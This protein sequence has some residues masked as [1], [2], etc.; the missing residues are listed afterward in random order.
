LSESEEAAKAVRNPRKGSKKHETFIRE[1]SDEPVDLLD[2][3]VFSHVSSQQPLTRDQELLRHAKAASRAATF[4]S[5]RD[6]RMIIEEPDRVSRKKDDN[7]PEYN[8]YD[9]VQESSD[10]AKR[11]YR[12]RIKF[13][14]KRSRQDAEDF[15]VEMT[16]AYQEARKPPPKKTNVNF[17]G[18]KKGFQVRRPTQ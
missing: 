12:D 18:R 7:V 9:E 14:N 16:E 3:N 4:K 17:D 5:T 8:A 13:S 2:Q 1:G 15:D 11:G 10:M 6:G